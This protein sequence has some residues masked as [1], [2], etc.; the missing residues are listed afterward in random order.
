MIIVDNWI[1]NDKNSTASLW[2]RLASYSPNLVL[3]FFFPPRLTASPQAPSP[4]VFVPTCLSS[5]QWDEGTGNVCHPGS[6]NL[7]TGN[8]L[9]LFRVSVGW[10]TPGWPWKP[11]VDDGRGQPWVP[12]DGTEFHFLPAGQLDLTWVRN[13][14]CVQPQGF[15]CLSPTATSYFN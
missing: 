14:C 13:F 15:W 5:N 7:P 11:R 8:Q 12:E 1:N 4:T 6:Q 9:S 3:F 10:Y 2:Q